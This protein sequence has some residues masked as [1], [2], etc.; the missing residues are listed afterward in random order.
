MN[1]P[2][3]CPE[4]DTAPFPDLDI[5][6]LAHAVRAADP[7]PCLEAARRLEAAGRPEQAAVLAGLAVSLQPGADALRLEYAACCARAGAPAEAAAARDKL[8]RQSRPEAAAPRPPTDRPQH[9]D[10]RP[11]R[12]L[13]VCGPDVMFVRH[14]EQHFAGCAEVETL[15]F[16]ERID[17]EALQR[18]MD[19]ADLTWF[20]WC[21][22]IL[23]YAARNLRKHGRVVCRLH[24]YEA[25][26]E[27]PAAVDW[28]FVDHLVFVAPHIQDIFGR[29]FGLKAPSSVIHNGIDPARF[30][31]AE[32]RP[33]F[34][35]AYVGSL[36][37]KKN[38]EMILQVAERLAR[39]DR[40][41]VVHI[42][43]RF[44]EPRYAY[45]FEK[46]IPAMGIEDNVRLYD[47]VDDIGAWL[48]DKSYILSTSVLES[49][50]VNILEAL[51]AGLK[52]VIHNW[53]GAD[54]LYPPEFLFNTVDE[55][56]ALVTSGP[57]D[58]AAYRNYVVEN[59]TQ[60]RE[61]S[62]ITALFNEL[63]TV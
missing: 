55:A 47:W 43:G 38:P 3:P 18:A 24:S 27:T 17:G 57:Y 1:A 59:Y 23:A 13:F 28:S 26:N 7:A 41:Y 5:E 56:A 29:H 11:L 42:A 49:Q 16:T 4:L 61:L 39:V 34:D 35:V 2:A 37:F 52:P 50:G 63:A 48:A 15:H 20:E 40:R 54:L 33:S 6:A 46:M 8:D 14:I 58:S 36:N 21:D 51:A 44:Q 25:F 53:V 32:R 45:Y 12:L 62:R 9:S 19:R 10:G 22:G 31:F 30:P 60:A